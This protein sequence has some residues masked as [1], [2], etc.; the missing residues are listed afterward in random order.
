MYKRQVQSSKLYRVKIAWGATWAAGCLA[1]NCTDIMFASDPTNPQQATGLPV[2]I[3]NKLIN[4]GTAVWVAAKNSAG[5]QWVDLFFGI[6][7]YDF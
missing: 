4:T 5:A 2:D 1:G 7:E 3:I 6:H